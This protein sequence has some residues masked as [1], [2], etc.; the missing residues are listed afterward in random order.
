MIFII[1]VIYANISQNKTSTTELDC[2]LDMTFVQS[3][4]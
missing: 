2:R 1:V 4:I 3:G